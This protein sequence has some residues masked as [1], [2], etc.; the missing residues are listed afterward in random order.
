MLCKLWILMVAMLAAQCYG[1][2]RT[3]LSNKEALTMSIAHYKSQYGGRAGDGYSVDYLDVKSFITITSYTKR[4]AEMKDYVAASYKSIHASVKRDVVVNSDDTGL[5]TY[6]V[7]HAYNPDRVQV[8]PN[9]DSCTKNGWT[10]LM[11]FTQ[12]NDRIGNWDI[13]CFGFAWNPSRSIYVDRSTTECSQHGWTS[14]FLMLTQDATSAESTSSVLNV[15]QAP[16]PQR[17]LIA[18]TDYKGNEHGWHLTAYFYVNE[19]DLAPTPE[20]IESIVQ[21]TPSQSSLHKR[22]DQGAPSL[23]VPTSIAM[24]QLF[25]EAMHYWKFTSVSRGS[26]G[27]LI[28]VFRETSFQ[29]FAERLGLSVNGMRFDA[30]SGIRDKNGVQFMNLQLQYGGQSY[31]CIIIQVGM[32]YSTTA[33]AKAFNRSLSYRTIVTVTQTVRRAKN[34]KSNIIETF[35]AYTMGTV[36]TM[37]LGASE[38]LG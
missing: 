29:E 38:L 13:G 31:A 17:M 11:S 8:F 34:G 33:I 32:K 6:C 15:W 30:Q 28:E 22:A 7:G 21:N 4:L 14:D 36:F 27:T 23:S 10:T 35:I 12:I 5:A 2:N 16:D 26:T 19:Y 1:Q 24:F 37:I 25:R 3:R 18:P 20:E 9:M